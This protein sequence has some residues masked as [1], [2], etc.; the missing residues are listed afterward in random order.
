MVKSVAAFVDDENI[1]K[2]L[3]ES[4]FVR[5]TTLDIV[6][7]V[8]GYKEASLKTKNWLYDIVKQKVEGLYD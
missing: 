7:S 8:N 2:E 4:F 5:N 3:I 6:Y 1:K